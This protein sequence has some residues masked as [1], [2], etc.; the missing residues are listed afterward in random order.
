M[1]PS[2]QSSQDETMYG[3]MHVD[4]PNNVTWTLEEAIDTIGVGTY[5]IFIFSKINNPTCLINDIPDKVAACFMQSMS[6]SIS[7]R[8]PLD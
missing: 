7:K 2:D 6:F 5:Q 4:D 1:L 8:K 3:S